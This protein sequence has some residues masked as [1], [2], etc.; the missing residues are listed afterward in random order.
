VHVTAGE[1]ELVRVLKFADER[2]RD[3]HGTVLIIDLEVG[4]EMH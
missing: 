1:N 4:V 2:L 3:H